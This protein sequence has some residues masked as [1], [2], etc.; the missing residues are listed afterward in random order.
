M[1][2]TDPFEQQYEEAIA[3]IEAAGN[4]NPYNDE[5]LRAAYLGASALIDENEALKPVEQIT[6]R[7]GIAKLAG[8]LATA[9]AD[10]TTAAEMADRVKDCDKIL[11]LIKP[12]EAEAGT[13]TTE[14]PVEAAS[15]QPQ[16]ATAATPAPRKRGRPRKADTSAGKTSGAKGN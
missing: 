16:E 12:Q 13:E 15:E 10:E 3:G 11:K 6:Y 7:K 4:F 9:H 1:T 8:E 5:V 14:A 2:S